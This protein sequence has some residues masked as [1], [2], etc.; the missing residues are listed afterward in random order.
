MRKICLKILLE[1]EKDAVAQMDPEEKL[2]TFSALLL[3]AAG[4]EADHRT[5]EDCLF[6]ITNFLSVGSE[7]C[8]DAGRCTSATTVY[9]LFRS[10]DGPGTGAEEGTGAIGLESTRYGKI[11]STSALYF[12][13]ETGI[14]LGFKIRA[15]EAMAELNES[16]KSDIQ[17]LALLTVA[18]FTLSFFFGTDTVGGEMA[19]ACLAGSRPFSTSGVL[20]PRQIQ[21]KI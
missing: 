9:I 19:L 13:V 20:K 10:K 17:S 12:E 7:E 1:L 6:L 2:T 15:I 14:N 21:L 3:F 4:E 18:I 16:D 11:P 8:T 5:K